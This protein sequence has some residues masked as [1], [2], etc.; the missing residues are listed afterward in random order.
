MTHFKPQLDRMKTELKEYGGLSA[1]SGVKL[2]DII[3]QL[4]A[5]VKNLRHV[6]R[7]K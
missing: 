4:A 7:K 3:E 6:V 2:L 5:E 1:Q